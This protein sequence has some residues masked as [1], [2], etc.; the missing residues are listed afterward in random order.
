LSDLAFSATPLVLSA[1]ASSGLTVSFSV[2]SG[3]ASISGNQLTLLGTG[4][5]TVRASQSGDAAWLA[6][7]PVERTFTVTANYNSWLLERFTPTEIAN[8]SLSG[9]NADFDQDGLSNL[10]E[11]ALGL[12]PKVSSA[13]GRPVVARTSTDWTFTY[14]RPSGRADVA[15][16][17]QS[18]TGLTTWSDVTTTHVLVSTSS[19]VETWRATV[20]TSGNPTCFF[21]LRVTR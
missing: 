15:Y 12:D 7:T 6:A 18:S 19:G 4:S 14:T 1:T 20:P 3:N 11:Y 16:V 17:V 5:I 9:P 21:R 2:V 10:V 13:A 8:V